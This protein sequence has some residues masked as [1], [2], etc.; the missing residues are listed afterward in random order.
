MP[1]S[2]RGL[3]LDFPNG[4]PWPVKALFV[5][6]FGNF[7]CFYAVTYWAEHYA[8]RQPSSISPF[9]IHFK[10]G[11]VV[12]V[13]S[14]LGIYEEWSLLLHFVIMAVIGTLFWWCL[15]TERAVRV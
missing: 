13:P 1:G 7:L 15:R 9:P 8:Q 11:V 3:Q 12:F 4:V 5:M 6:L 14:W 10:G 2:R